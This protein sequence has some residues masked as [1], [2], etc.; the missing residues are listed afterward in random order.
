M[1]RIRKVSRTIAI[2]EVEAVYSNVVDMT[3]DVEKLELIG[4]FDNAGALNELAKLNKPEHTY[5]S[6]KSVDHHNYL[7][8][9]TEKDF[10]SLASREDV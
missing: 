5:V 9:M 7:Y 8:S 6:V 4:E 2:T 1:A 3:M 10:V